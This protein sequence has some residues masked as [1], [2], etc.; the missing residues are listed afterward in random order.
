MDKRLYSSSTLTHTHTHTPC[1][2]ILQQPAPAAVAAAPA[3]PAA[4]TKALT[5]EEKRKIRAAK[6]GTT[7]LPEAEKKKLR[8]ERF[9]S[10]TNTGNAA[11]AKSNNA[12]GA[13][14][15][16]WKPAGVGKPADAPRFIPLSK[17]WI[18]CD[19]IYL[20][21]MHA[22]IYTLCMHASGCF[23]V[24]ITTASHHHHSHPSPHNHTLT[25]ITTHS[26]NHTHQA[27]SM[28]ELERRKQRAAKFGTAPPT[29]EEEDAAKR[30]ARAV[31]YGTLD[32]ATKRAIRM[33]RF[34]GKEEGDAKTEK[35]GENAPPAKKVW[36]LMGEVYLLLLLFICC[37]CVCTVFAA[38][39]AQMRPTAQPV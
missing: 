10:A 9:G 12:Q 27:M 7:H 19:R 16:V 3:A 2:I 38:T 25:P 37:C 39:P 35:R 32:E 8:A 30:L 24:I 26:H 4:G 23:I 6:F 21:I 20:H 14:K 17:V 13:A 36:V 31:K 18:V 11:S 15:P 33:Q 5:E 29:K 34:G 22:C 1:I 28:E